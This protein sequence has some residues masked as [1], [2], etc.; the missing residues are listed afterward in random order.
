[1]KGNRELTPS[2]MRLPV[3][4]KTWLK[5]R[6]IDNRRSLNSEVTVRLEESRRREES[7]QQGA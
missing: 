6:A 1:M 3:D 2:P 5:H 7:E 4:L